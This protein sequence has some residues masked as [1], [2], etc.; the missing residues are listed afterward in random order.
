MEQNIFDEVFNK[1]KL[2]NTPEKRGIFLLGVLTQMLLNKQYSERGS[3]PFM[4]KLKSLKM[5]E[6]DIKAL[7][8]E[9]HNKLEE[10]DA[11]D[12][13]K[14]LIA[15]EASKYLLQAGDSWKMPVDEINFYFA[16]GMNMNDEIAKVVYNNPKVQ[17]KTNE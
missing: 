10:Y 3:K 16:C 1:Y 2:L 9:V 15:Q 8:S 6:K 11:F 17:E 5:D 7:L 12:K 4:K 13:G 14:R